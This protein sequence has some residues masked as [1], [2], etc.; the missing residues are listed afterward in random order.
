[1]TTTSARIVIDC[2]IES[3]ESS[4]RDK[5]VD[6]GLEIATAGEEMSNGGERVDHLVFIAPVSARPAGVEELSVGEVDAVLQLVFLRFWR[7]VK[8]YVPLLRENGTLA[9]VLPE[10]AGLEVVGRSMEAAAVSAVRSMAKVLAFE[11]DGRGISVVTVSLSQ[12][13]YEAM[14]MEPSEANT[15]ASR[16][17]QVDKIAGAIFEVLQRGKSTSTLFFSSS[18]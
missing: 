2:P 12:A 11:C 13:D 14:Q 4:L 1:M 17:A 3:L 15:V 10:E 6:S 9:L 5:A 7:F 18:P 8:G 16:S